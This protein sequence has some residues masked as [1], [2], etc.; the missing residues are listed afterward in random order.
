MSALNR[1][2]EPQAPELGAEALLPLAGST[3]VLGLGNELRGDDG[4]GPAVIRELA[5]CP[6]LPP[7]V[8]VLDGGLA[9]LE[10]V[11]LLKGARRA[12]IVDAAEQGLAPGEWR[13]L[14]AG[15]L[16]EHA[17][18]EEHGSPHATG[19]AQALALGEALGSL[20]PHVVVYAV[21]PERVDFSPGL[22]GTLQATIPSLCQAILSD[23]VPPTA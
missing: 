12:L 22:S 8:T 16:I 10:T 15:L 19:L 13:R 3:L 14:P 2:A 23:L 18:R 9:G 4:I 6:S 7:E 11:L 21:Q 5:S 20:P 17:S 1:S